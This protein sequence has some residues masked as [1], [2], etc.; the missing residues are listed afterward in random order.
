MRFY[1][2]VSLITALL[3]SLCLPCSA[4]TIKLGSLAPENSPWDLSLR[5][6]ASE[7]K[8]ISGG[9][10]RLRVYPGGIAGGEADMIRKIRIGQLDAAALT[11]TGLSRISSEVLAI[12]LPLMYRNEKE[13]FYVLEKMKPQFEKQLEKKKFKA[14]LWDRAGW[15]YFFSKKPIISPADLKTQKLAV[16]AGSTTI[17]SAWRSAGFQ[18]IPIDTINIMAALQSGMISATYTTPIGAATYQWFGIARYMCPVKVAPLVCAVVIGTRSW[19]KIPKS[20]RPRLL[21]AAIRASK[22]LDSEVIQLENKAMAV[23]KKNGLIIT[24]LTPDVKK[25]W[26]QE[27]K[28]GNKTLI[29]SFIKK[30]TYDQVMTHLNTYKNKNA[31]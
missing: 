24:S 5:K 9:R 30:E 11:A 25:Q 6:V 15:I 18:A 20:L 17:L 16:T 29:G 14:L 1:F 22:S 19:R 10:V 3:F 13:L 28:K 8:N 7:W 2:K 23:M 31:Q 26:L 4:V 21:N 12:T 27:M